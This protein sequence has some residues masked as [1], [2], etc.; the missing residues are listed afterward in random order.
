[1]EKYHTYMSYMCVIK[2]DVYIIPIEYAFPWFL[3]PLTQEEII[4]ILELNYH[5]GY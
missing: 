1:M 5:A 2:R 3:Q 4:L